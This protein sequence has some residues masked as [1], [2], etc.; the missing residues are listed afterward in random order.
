V[1]AI[2]GEFTKPGLALSAVR[3]DVRLALTLA[4]AYFHLTEQSLLRV[5]GGKQ[6]PTYI[7]V[8]VSSG[9]RLLIQ[10]TF[11]GVERPL[12]GLRVLFDNISVHMLRSPHTCW[13]R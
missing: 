13:S 6:Q 3:S 8:I 7:Y 1:T 12:Y 2:H 5:D 10:L 9:P 11:P 4:P